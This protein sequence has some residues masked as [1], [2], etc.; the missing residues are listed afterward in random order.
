MIFALIFLRKKPHPLILLL[1][2][3]E[4]LSEQTLMDLFIPALKQ[5]TIGENAVIISS[6][7][8]PLSY[9]DLLE[10]LVNKLLLHMVK[11]E[12]SPYYQPNQID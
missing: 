1:A 9:K 4:I 7:W 6:P 11:L 12:S 3:A 10:Q 5:T 2:I 8:F